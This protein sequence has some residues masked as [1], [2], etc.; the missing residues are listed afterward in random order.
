MALPDY[1]KVEPGT[2]IVLGESGASGVTVTLS[3]DALADGSGRMSAEFDLGAQY[4][5]WYAVYIFIETGTSPTAGNRLDVYA[6]SSFDGTT[7]PGG[8]SGSDGAW[9]ADGNE[10]EWAAQLEPIGPYIATNDTNTIGVQA[11]V[12]WRPKSRYNCIVVDNNMGQAVRDEATAT[13]NDSRIIII[14][15][16]SLMQDAA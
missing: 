1:F 6:A 16:R 9:P 3:F 4:D 11:P 5:E 2:A 12:L 15:L 13:N 10:D 7:Y 14:P 8:V